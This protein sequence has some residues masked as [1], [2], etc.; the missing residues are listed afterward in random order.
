MPEFSFSQ[1]LSKLDNGDK[2][3]PVSLFFGF[4]EFLGEVLLKKLSDNFLEKKTDFNFKRYYFDDESETSWQEIIEEAK[5]SSFFI[6]SR[7]I[8]IA[9]IRD[10]KKLLPSKDDLNLLSEY[11]K[12]PN[13][14]TILVIYISLNLTM[15]DFKLLRREKI[16]KIFT[17]LSSDNL[18]LVN[19]D[20]ISE[21]EVQQYVKKY[22]NSIGISITPSALEKII[23][24]KGD[25]YISI[26]HQLRKMEISCGEEKNIDSE[27]VEEV[28]TGIESHSIWEL[29]ETI[30]KEDTEGYLKILN[31]LFVNGIKP[32]IIMGTLI[33]HY[34]KIFIAKFMLKKNININDI[35]R[36]LNQPRFLLQKFINLSRN[37]PGDRLKRIQK[38]I[39]DMDYESKT[40]GEN[41][42]KLSLENFIFQIKR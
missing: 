22:L 32:V 4:N 41:S 1:F 9:T 20:K 12:N 28:I 18:N 23:D 27:D 16:T 14:N 39:Y 11:I 13:N 37:F 33:S 19:L 2:R 15:D 10:Q 7:K 3:F 24:I 34:N 8:L 17:H 42:A 5:S 38:V 6:Q 36:V 31:Y 30:E 21:K 26:L 40:S 29:T 25:D 35:G